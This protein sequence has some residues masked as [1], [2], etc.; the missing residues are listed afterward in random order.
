MNKIFTASDV[1]QERGAKSYRELLKIEQVHFCESSVFARVDF[2]RWISD[3]ECGGASYVD[4]ADNFFYCTACKN[5]SHDGKLRPVIFPDNIQEIEQELLKRNV[6]F[7]KGI[8]GSQGMINPATKFKISRSWKSG[9]TVEVLR[10]QR[11]ATQGE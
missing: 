7:S 6:E 8:T 1:A 4:P 3:C 9:E 5:I 11:I 2:G 10:A